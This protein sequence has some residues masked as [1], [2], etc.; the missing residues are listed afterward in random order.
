MATTSAALLSSKSQSEPRSAQSKSDPV[1]II[2]N[3][4]TS[5]VVLS[6]VLRKLYERAGIESQFKSLKT[7]EQWGF[8]SRGRAHIQIEVWEGTMATMLN[9]LVASGNVVEAGTHDATTREEWWYPLYVEELCP[10]LPNWEAL[11]NCSHLFTTPTSGTK[12]RY[13]GGPWEKPDKARVR[14]LDLNFKVERANEGDDLWV[15][16]E[17]SY[18]KKEP[19]IL[20]NWTPNWVESKYEGRFVE[21]PE[22]HPKCETDASWGVSKKWKYDCGNP[23][24]G[25]LKKLAWKPVKEKWPCAF[26]IL[27]N[28]NLSNKMIADASAYVDVQGMSPERAASAWMRDNADIWRKWIPTHCENP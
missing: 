2:V 17:K 15:E 22:H 3:D 14:A 24:Q 21:F 4:W 20:F 13:L 12:G 1:I 27:Q 7:A 26:S 25:W 16:L 9:R 18:S 5:Q 10:G 6:H 19:I 23:K 11:K 28:F 8:L